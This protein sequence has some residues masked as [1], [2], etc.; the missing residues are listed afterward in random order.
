MRSEAQVPPS[1]LEARPHTAFDG[2]PY[3]DEELQVA[4]SRAHSIMAGES[5]PIF[6]AIATEAGLVFMSDEPIWFLHPETDEQ[7]AF[8]GD[9]VFARPIETT[10]AT[11]R[12][13]LLVMEIVSTNDR[14]KELKDT[15]FQHLLNEYNEV[16]EFA[17]VFPDLDDPRALTWHRLVDGRYE[18]QVVAPGGRVTSE[19]VA[20]LELLVLPRERWSDGYKLDVYYRGELRPRLLGERARAKQ[21]KARAEQEKARAEQEK[22]RAE[23]EKARAEQEKARAEQEKA[24]AE[25][26]AQRLRELGVE[27]DDGGA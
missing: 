16:P 21:E 27:P 4:Q 13:L 26:L 15:R 19:V 8:Y 9:C 25:R 22:A 17:L 5:L 23:Q 14:R 11:A 1:K 6:S 24:R 10:R 20:G 2:T 7:K 12:D 3:F 18:A